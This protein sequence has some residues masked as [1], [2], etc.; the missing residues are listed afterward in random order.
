[1]ILFS[2]L[3]LFSCSDDKKHDIEVLVKE[4][5]NKEIRFPENPIFTRYVTDT[6]PYRIPKTD[7][8]VVVFVDSVGC[9]SC[10]LQLPRWKE[11]MHEVDSLSDG[12]VPFV[13]FFQT[14][15]VRDSQ[16]KVE[17]SDL[18]MANVEA[19]A[20]GELV[21]GENQCYQVFTPADWFHKDQ[22]FV[23]CYT[24]TQ[25]KGRNFDI[26]RRCYRN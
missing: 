18:A 16:Q 12:N 4:W 24:C 3:F 1:M 9:I 25:K 20:D 26:S 21:Q 10:K 22:V 23:D 7:Y 2:S 15:D 8:K 17:M 11:F 5:N 19:L 13:F 6:I 14:K